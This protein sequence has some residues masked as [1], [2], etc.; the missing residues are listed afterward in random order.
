MANPKRTGKHMY[1]YI[2]TLGG[3]ENTRRLNVVQIGDEEEATISW[4]EEDRFL[5]VEL[6][7]LKLQQDRS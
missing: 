5:N 6:D 7:T 4:T 3:P 1:I 2:Y